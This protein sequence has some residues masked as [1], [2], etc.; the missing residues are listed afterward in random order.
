MKKPSHV[1]KAV[2]LLKN[3]P[4]PQGPSSALVDKTLAGVESVLSQD[5]GGPTSKWPRR[6]TFGKLAAAA[7]ILV[8]IGF[9]AGRQNPSAALSERQ[10]QLLESTLLETLE[11]TIAARFQD[12]FTADWQ[13]ALV[14][15]Y[16]KLLRD[17]DQ[18]V[19]HK[20][21]Q[22]ALQ[23]L[24]VSH[25][26]TEQALENLIGQIR[27]NEAQ[28]QARFASALNQLEYDHFL[29]DSQVRNGLATFADLARTHVKHTEDLV[30]FVAQEQSPVLDPNGINTLPMHD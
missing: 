6:K 18:Q 1:D 17:V 26:K 10:L 7:A 2:D 15:T 11:P 30:S 4:V 13:K 20:L 24:A 8:G 23:V 29:R 9:L 25:A 12:R 16:G 28:Q 3:L 19:D 27:R 21:N 22:Y 14:L 5:S